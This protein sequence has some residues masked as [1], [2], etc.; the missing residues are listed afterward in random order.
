M[1]DY[2]EIEKL[3]EEL[4]KEEVKKLLESLDSAYEFYKDSS[5]NEQVLQK[6]SSSKRQSAEI[7]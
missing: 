2:K 5:E 1:K 3:V 7:N 6:I 4:T